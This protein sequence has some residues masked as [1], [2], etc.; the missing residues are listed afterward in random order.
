[1]K[2]AWKLLL[3][4]WAAESCKQR[5]GGVPEPTRAMQG[6][7]GRENA[8]QGIRI[9]CLGWF[10]EYQVCDKLHLISQLCKCDT[11]IINTGCLGSSENNLTCLVHFIHGDS[12]YVI[13]W[14]GLVLFPLFFPKL[15]LGACKE[16]RKQTPRGTE[17]VHCG[18]CAYK[19]CLK[20]LN[21]LFLSQNWFQR[22]R[23]RSF[24]LY[25]FSAK[26]FLY[27]LLEQICSLLINGQEWIGQH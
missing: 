7:V 23:N 24:S 25:S 19:I 1:M 10:L 3:Q 18:K 26:Y 12:F 16:R 22:V 15:A 27:S 20:A 6:R 17:I 21:I 14:V 13:C 2:K 5:A 4:C 9:C 11:F 8:T